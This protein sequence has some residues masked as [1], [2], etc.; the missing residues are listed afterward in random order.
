MS[1]FDT[2]QLLTTLTTASRLT[3]A[4]PTWTWPCSIEMLVEVGTWAREDGG[5][6]SLP[7]A[8]FFCH[9]EQWLTAVGQAS[10]VTAPGGPQAASPGSPDK[11]QPFRL[12]VRSKLS[13]VPRSPAQSLAAA[14]LG[15]PQVPP[16]PRH[17]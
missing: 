9:W 11:S 17:C 13:P 10:L 1:W 7:S 6:G 8:L 16:Y 5:K 12:Y 2:G 15:V 4:L 3:L 14:T